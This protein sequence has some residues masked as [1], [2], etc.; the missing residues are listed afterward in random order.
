[1]E[2]EHGFG[3]D[4]CSSGMA[5]GNSSSAEGSPFSVHVRGTGGCFLVQ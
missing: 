1:M 2:R 4:V 5:W 3:F